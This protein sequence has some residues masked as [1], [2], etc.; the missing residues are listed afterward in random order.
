MSVLV[1]TIVK[2][3]LICYSPTSPDGMD[4]HT[5]CYID[6]ELDVG[7]VV[8][9]GATRDLCIVSLA[10]RLWWWWWLAS[11]ESHCW[12]LE[13]CFCSKICCYRCFACSLYGKTYLNILVR[14]PDVISIGSQVLRSG[15]DSELNGALVAKRLV[16]PSSDRS[17]LLDCGDTVV[18]NENLEKTTLVSS[19]RFSVALFRRLYSHL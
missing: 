8:V 15:H 11:F 1:D 17:D 7:I 5:L 2:G 9:V 19:V 18:C 12:L 4:F 3:K 6:N 16:G 10:G 14:H 13:S